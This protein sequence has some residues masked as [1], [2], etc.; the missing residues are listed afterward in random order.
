MPSDMTEPIPVEITNTQDIYDP[1]RIDGLRG[2]GLNN[3]EIGIALR[4]G[5]MEG[6]MMGAMGAF[7]VA[8][9]MLPVEP[10]AIPPLTVSSVSIT[11]GSVSV[12][13]SSVTGGGGT[14]D[15]EVVVNA[16]I[17][18]TLTL[19]DGATAELGSNQHRLRSQRRS[20]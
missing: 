5:T 12:N 16:N 9:E 20:S 14:G 3:R 10:A 13:G 8:S 7:A 17:N 1:A 6:T 2:Q 18:N 11:A 19:P 4:E 15:G